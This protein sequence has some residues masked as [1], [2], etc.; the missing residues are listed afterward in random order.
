MCDDCDD[1][2]ATREDDSLET[3]R[4]CR[5]PRGLQLVIVWY[6]TDPRRVGEVFD[7]PAGRRVVIGRDPEAAHPVRRRP[8]GD[9]PRRPPLDD[10]HLSRRHLYVEPH[11]SQYLTVWR[12]GSSAVFVNDQPLER[13]E[14]RQ[15]VPGA[16][17]QLGKR[18]LLLVSPPGGRASSAGGI[19][20]SSSKKVSAYRRSRSLR[21]ITHDPRWSATAGASS[22]AMI[23]SAGGWDPASPSGDDTTPSKLRDR[24]G[25]LSSERPGRVHER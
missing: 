20:S 8:D 25:A 3:R 17:V 24:S 23:A 19:V 16:L 15:L 4:P 13:D 12:G 18:L 21:H 1:D 14:P 7:V 9:D 5:G 22:S 11:G 6:Y 2:K 10:P